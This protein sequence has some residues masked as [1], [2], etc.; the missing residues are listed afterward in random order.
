MNGRL[1]ALYVSCVMSLYMSCNG[2]KV[3]YWLGMIRRGEAEGSPS[4]HGQGMVIDAVR[5][6]GNEFFFFPKPVFID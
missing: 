4:G 1:A 2:Y 6:E 3:V 5:Y